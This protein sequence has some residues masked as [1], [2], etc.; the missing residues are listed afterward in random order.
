MDHS[1]L[2]SKLKYYGV[3]GCSYDFLSS[4][5][6]GRS[7]YVEF[8]GHKSNTLPISTGVPQGSVLGP[9]L[10]LV[11]IN[12]LP[13]VSNIFDMLMYADDTTLYCNINQNVTAEVINGELL[14]INQWL[15]ANKLSLNVSKTK[16]M[17]FH[18]HNRS[19]SYPDLQINGNKIERVTEFNFLGLV[20]QSNLSWNKHINHI[21]LKVSKAIGI[22]YRL[23]SVYPLAVLLTLYNTLVLPYFN[24]CILSW[25]SKIKENHQLYLLQKKAVRIITHSNYIAHTEP[26]CKQYGIIKLTDMFSLA[27]WKFYYKLMNNQLP[28]YFSQM[29]PV[30]PI[31]CTRYEVR[32]PMFHLPDIRHSFGEQSIGY[33]LIKQLNA[34][35]GSLTTDMVLTESFLI[36]KVHIKRAV[37]DGYSDHC[38]ID[39][40]YVCNR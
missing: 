39:N 32:N 20:L 14:K 10:F 9:L 35:E 5:L 3:T 8:S 13:L 25:G 16:F 2:L 28:T 40:C 15:G 38:E 31:I 30:L 33:C 19:V 1:I 11:C 22:I 26:L 24:Y 29:K 4:Y 18:T 34:E 12:D 21:S 23:K 37:I 36:Y 7:Q 27:I 17:V 6:T